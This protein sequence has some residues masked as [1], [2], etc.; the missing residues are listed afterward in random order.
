MHPTTRI[1]TAFWY[2]C[3]IVILLGAA[4]YNGFP[5]V[6]SD[7]G[8]YINSGFHWDVPRD[9][10]IIYGIFLRLASLRYSLW[11]AVGVQCAILAALLLRAVRVLAPRTVAPGW[12]VGIVLLSSWAT[13]LAWF[14]GQVMPDIFTGIGLLT[15]LLLYFDDHLGRLG[16]GLLLALLL[17]CAIMHS[18]NLLT[19]SLLGLLVA[20][21]AW[22][23]RHRTPVLPGRRV[24]P[25]LAVVLSG[26]LVLPAIH[27][28]FGG[29]FAISRS[30][31]MFLMGR[32]VE[33]GVLDKYLAKRCDKDT[34][35]EL[36]KFRNEL[37]N[38]AITFLWD[39]QSVPNR[40]GGW[41][42]HETE[43]KAIIQDVLT[44]PRYY[45]LLLTE[46]IQ[47]TLRQVVSVEHGDGLTPF[48]ENSNPFWKV[49]ESF[50]YELREY[51]SSRQN[52]SRLDFTDLTARNQ[53]TLL[54]TV[55]VLCAALG[56]RLRHRLTARER[57]W[58]LVAITGIVTNAGVT[59]SLANVL[60]RL[61]T[62]VVWVLP[63][64]VL[65]LLVAHGP[66][67]LAYLR[68]WLRATPSD[69][70]SN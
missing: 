69:A 35:P 48:R 39:G 37:P 56:S 66:A 27:A 29:G 55:G 5:L 30:S 50:P 58:L 60:S 24:V 26:W 6:T 41:E 68:G 46:A 64:S 7:T 22:V 36:C 51:L 18:S 40:T 59:G 12:R 32:L 42:A 13:G 43:Y 70:S 33:S 57:L 65:C 61:Q 11:L 31:Y 3:T 15:M 14:S 8:A 63:F 10:P 25:V 62:R 17:L 49:Q 9:R 67:L 38:D 1:E 4:L 47:A 21:V 53:L 54:L 28:A 52:Q 45:P 2:G 20:A 34:P 16:R 44:S 23:V 19:F